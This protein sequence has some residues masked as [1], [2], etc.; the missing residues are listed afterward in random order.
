MPRNGYEGTENQEQECEYVKP[1]QRP[2]YKELTPREGQDEEVNQP[3]PEEEYFY[4][5]MKGMEE[6][7]WMWKD[8]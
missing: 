5:P 6:L 7:E 2:I 1:G 3:E 4:E 8:I